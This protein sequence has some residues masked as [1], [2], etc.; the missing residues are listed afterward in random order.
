MNNTEEKKEFDRKIGNRIRT[1][2][3]ERGWSQEELASRME[4]SVACVSRI[5]RGV[6]GCTT[7]ILQKACEALD[8]SPDQVMGWSNKKDIS[9]ASPE[10]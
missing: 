1:F 8:K 9:V 4:V 3:D 7:Y 6:S 2:R 10:N 5:E